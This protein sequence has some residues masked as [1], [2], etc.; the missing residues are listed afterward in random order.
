[1]FRALDSISPLNGKETDNMKSGFLSGHKTY[2]LALA[3]VVGAFVGYATGDLTL[4]QALETAWAGGLA[5]TFRH[6]L[7]KLGQ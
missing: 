1:M 7:A 5:A 6:A 2:L 3:A 4:Q